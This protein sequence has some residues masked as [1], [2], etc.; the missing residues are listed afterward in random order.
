M[1]TWVVAVSQAKPIL[2]VA[3]NACGRLHA[4]FL[5]TC[6]HIP[7]SLHTALWWVVAVLPTNNTPV[8][9]SAPG[10]PITRFPGSLPTASLASPM[11]GLWMVN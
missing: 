2:N 6:T 7:G 8:G 1:C 4:A 9:C 11:E 3:A 5:V 10:R